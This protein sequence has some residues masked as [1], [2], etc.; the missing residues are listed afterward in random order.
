MPRLARASPPAACWRGLDTVKRQRGHV[1]PPVV[2]ALCHATSPLGVVR[3]SVGLISGQGGVP[4]CPGTTRLSRGKRGSC[5]IRPL[6]Q[7][8][9]KP[10]CPQCPPVSRKLLLCPAPLRALW[11]KATGVMQNCLRWV[12]SHSRRRSSVAFAPYAPPVGSLVGCRSTL[13]LVRR[14]A[15]GVWPVA[16]GQ[17]CCV[18]PAHP[19]ASPLRGIG[20]PL[21]AR[22][23]PRG[24]IS[25]ALFF[26][27]RDLY[28][29]RRRGQ[30]T[31]MWP[32]R[33]HKRK[34][35]EQVRALP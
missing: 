11:V 20:P 13:A 35:P 21:G 24:S 31:V 2:V 22:P 14:F 32:L 10:H 27:W 8:Y 19:L 7:N 17:S 6:R 9:I 18:C 15:Q 4:P 25:P 23:P 16:C 30:S 29:V 33:S 12:R 34:S 28:C 1:V 5:G 26:G 3:C